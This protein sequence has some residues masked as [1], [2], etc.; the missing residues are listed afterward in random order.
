MA[1]D[2]KEQCFSRQDWLPVRG[3]QAT[4]SLLLNRMGAGTKQIIQIDLRNFCCNT[5]LIMIFNVPDHHDSGLVFLMLHDER[6]RPNP[7]AKPEHPAV[8]FPSNTN[9]LWRLLC[10]ILPIDDG[11]FYPAWS[12][13]K[14]KSDRLSHFHVHDNFH[15]TRYFRCSHYSCWSRDSFLPVPGPVQNAVLSSSSL[16]L[17]ARLARGK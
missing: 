16:A 11:S 15:L 13:L 17:S 9:D 5:R 2:H 10:A 12:P 6:R 7:R 3:M 8:P 4:K 1:S 14:Q